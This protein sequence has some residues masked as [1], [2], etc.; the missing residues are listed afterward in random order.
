MDVT[1]QTV[2]GT[3]V[4][5]SISELDQMVLGEKRFERL[6]DIR[7][8]LAVT[9]SVPGTVR[10][11]STHHL[12]IEHQYTWGSN[13]EVGFSYYITDS[14]GSIVRGVSGE[15]ADEPDPLAK[16]HLMMDRLSGATTGR[17]W[18]KFMSTYDV[19][20][21]E[22]DL[23]F[24]L[25]SGDYTLHLQQQ[26]NFMETGYWIVDEE[27]SIPFTVWSPSGRI[28]SVTAPQD[29]FE[30]TGFDVEVSHTNTMSVSGTFSV[31]IVDRD[32]GTVVY[33]G[34]SHSLASGEQM[35]ETAT[36]VMP[37]KG[38]DLTARLFFESL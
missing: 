36:L 18:S 7:T 15:L 12:Q 25:L 16:G 10:P 13:A 26:L 19:W 28:D 32:T 27:V 33:D 2:S 37:G 22:R 30:G 24:D 35:V 17:W 9:D 21:W 11:G 29:A 20:G 38:F 4:T 34:S 23:T 5:G 6:S 3:P 14:T 8:Q 31:E 1:P